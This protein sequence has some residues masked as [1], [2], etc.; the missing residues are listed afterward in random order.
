MPSQSPYPWQESYALGLE[1]IDA[2]HETL[3]DIVGRIYA[4]EGHAG[5]KEEIRLI[6]YDLSD[7]MQQH[8]T[9]EEAY[10]AAIGY[11]GLDEHREHHRK[12]IEGVGTLVRNPVKLGILKSKMKVAAKKMLVDHILV[13]DAKIKAWSDSCTGP[14]P[15]FE[16]EV[17]MTFEEERQ[18]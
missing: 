5:V 12:I 9:N 2:Q 1:G 17:V 16:G 10:M 13:E 11:P 7:Y 4:L 8:F 3:F 14:L 15:S 6:L 18:C